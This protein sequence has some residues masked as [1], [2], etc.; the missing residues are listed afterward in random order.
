MNTRSDDVAEFDAI[1][2]TVQHYIDG[3][4]EG[5]GA[6]MKVAFHDNAQIFGYGQGGL[7]AALI[8]ELFDRVDV[9]GPAPET[10]A[11]IVSIEISKTVA[12]VR[13]ELDQWAGRRFT[14]FFTLLKIDG[15]WTI[16]N[17]AFHLHSPI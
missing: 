12:T 8:Q 6:T 11:R 4:R 17:K 3:A 9:T 10:Q 15:T 16:M 2:A 5:S 13:L 1:T 14:D 7:F